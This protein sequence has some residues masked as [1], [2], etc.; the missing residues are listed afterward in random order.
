MDDAS[1]R[2]FRIS[3]LVCAGVH[4]RMN[5]EIL[6]GPEITAVW[7]RYLSCRRSADLSTLTDHYLP[8]VAR[9]AMGR[10]RRRGRV[11][12]DALDEA[13]ADGMLNLVQI[14]Q[15]TTAYCPDEFRHVTISKL[16]EALWCSLDNRGHGKQHRAQVSRFIFFVRADL[17]QK[18]QRPPTIDEIRDGIR[19][20]SRSPAKYLAALGWAMAGVQGFEDWKRVADP[21]TSDPSRRA[22]NMEVIHLASMGL[23]GRDRAIFRLTL[24]GMTK[25]EIGRKVGCHETNVH[26]RLCRMFWL[27]RSDPKLAAYL[28]VVPDPTPPA[29]PRG[30]NWPNFVAT[31]A[32][33]AG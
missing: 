2:R 9:A 16:M 29:R 14:I 21:K 26:Y 33:L 1:K 6:D 7:K 32:R 19:S 25:A 18:L 13:F 5:H 15:E 20:R 30:R 24:Q 10:S 12:V 31:P 27:M 4:E 23:K 3:E 8:L 22:L 11:P 28:G 17:E